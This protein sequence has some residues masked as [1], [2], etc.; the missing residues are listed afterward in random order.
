MAAALSPLQ[1]LA[2]AAEVVRGGS[3]LSGRVRPARRPDVV[4][5]LDR[6]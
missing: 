1:E 3:R 2:D 4:A 6:S 5:N